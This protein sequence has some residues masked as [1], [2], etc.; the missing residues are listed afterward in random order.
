M[1][2]AYRQGKTRFRQEESATSPGQLVSRGLNPLP[3]A[4]TQGER[5]APATPP[6]PESQFIHSGKDQASSVFSLS[7][8]FF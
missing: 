6:S 2:P 7:F 3:L 1:L 8:F 5:Q 4:G